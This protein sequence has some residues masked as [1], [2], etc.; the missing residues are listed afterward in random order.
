MNEPPN[1]EVVVFAAALELPADQRGAF[2]DPG[3][4][5]KI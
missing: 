5:A 3:Q 4:T 2:L 1:P